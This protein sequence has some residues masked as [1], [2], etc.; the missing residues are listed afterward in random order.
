MSNLH[1]YSIHE[2]HNSLLKQEITTTDLVN[3]FLQQIE[4]HNS[5][6]NIFLKVFEQRAL[7]QAAKLQKELDEGFCR[8]HLHGIPIAIKDIFDFQSHT[9]SGG[10]KALRSNSR[11]V[12]TVSKNW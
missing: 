7:Q 6:L 3:H 2:L 8:G 12:A 10:S 9:A 5:D 11:S 4:R 1:T